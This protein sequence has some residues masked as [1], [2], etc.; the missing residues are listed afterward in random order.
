MDCMSLDELRSRIQTIKT[1][2]DVVASILYFFRESDEIPTNF[3][4]IHRAF[5]AVKHEI[6][7]NEFTFNSKGLYP[8]S[9]LLEN[10]FSRLA[11]SG[12]ISCFNPVYEKYRIDEAQKR[13]I[14]RISLSKF[15][16]EEQKSLEK[17]SGVVESHLFS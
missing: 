7:F 17:I 4:K 8:Y 14:Q 11:I 16:P 9:P 12:L 5:N 15:D 10:I 1:P 2:L 3:E 6:Y 13:K